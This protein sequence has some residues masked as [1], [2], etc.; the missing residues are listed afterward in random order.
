MEQ[1]FNHIPAK[2]LFG[3]NS[4]LVEQVSEATMAGISSLGTTY[5]IATSIIALL[6]IF[7]LVGYFDLFRYLMLS[8]FS[9]QSNSSDMHLFSREAKNIKLF[10]SLIGACLIGLL[11]MRLSVMGWAAP[12]MGVGPE[13]SA[14]GACGLTFLGII[15]TL[16]GEGALL[17]IVGALSGQQ[18]ACNMLWHSK[19]LY[20]SLAIAL[21]SPMLIL[22]LLT[23]GLTAQ[24][25][26]GLSVL[27]C[28]LTL[29]LFIKETFLLFRLQRF[30]IFH[31]F[32]YLCA[33]EIFPI[34]LLLA[35]VLRG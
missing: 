22:V 33:L 17:Y 4:K 24:L 16:F 11:V 13:F 30:S 32:L 7:I 3:A 26:L 20:F 29:L 28:L 19:L 34:S 5:Q 12:M 23:E 35:P 9:S 18:D 31:W 27:I 25:A 1:I 6:F 14:W 10:T 8:S 15:A 21:L 2:E